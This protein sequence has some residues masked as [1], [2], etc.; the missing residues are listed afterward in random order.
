MQSIPRELR[1][2][3]TRCIR[4]SNVYIG[5]GRRCA[6]SVFELVIV[7]MVMGILGA[8]AIPTF[9]DS[10]LIHRI[11]CAAR[12]VKTDLEL[13]R[14]QARLT[15]S[16][17][18]VTFANS[19]YTISNTKHLDRPNLIYSVNLKKEPYLLN[20]AT[21]NFSNATTVTFDGYGMPS[22]GGTVTLTL[23]TYQSTVTLNGTTGDVTI[24]SAHSGNRTTQISGS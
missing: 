2:Q 15:S 23:K 3:R 21:A 6:F 4:A 17:Q 7:L 9:F 12:R 16:N 13:A 5:R 24:S 11:D 20:S 22:S 10:L 1:R 18:T 19:A 14:T 8:V